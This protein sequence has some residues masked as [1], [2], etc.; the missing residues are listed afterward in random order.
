MS[1]NPVHC[2]SYWFDVQFMSKSLLDQGAMCLVLMP[3]L[4]TA[5]RRMNLL[6][7]VFYGYE[8]LTNTVHAWRSLV[9]EFAH[10]TRHAMPDIYS[11]RAT[12]GSIEYYNKQFRSRIRYLLS[13]VLDEV[14][15]TVIPR[16]VRRLYY[17]ISM[18]LLEKCALV[19]YACSVDVWQTTRQQLVE[20]D[21]H[22]VLACLVR[23]AAVHW[24][25]CD[26]SVQHARGVAAM[27]FT[28]RTWINIDHL[29]PKTRNPIVAN[30]TLK[31]S[32]LVP[33]D[34]SVVLWSKLVAQR[35]SLCSVSIHYGKVHTRPTDLAH[36]MAMTSFH[37]S[38]Q[39]RKLKCT[40]LLIS[41]DGNPDLVLHYDSTSRGGP[42]ASNAPSWILIESNHLDQPAYVTQFEHGDGAVDVIR[43]SSTGGRGGGQTTRK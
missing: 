16:D 29:L 23:S 17:N 24:S 12:Y 5:L 42:G 41:S 7:A 38:Q 6:E 8:A 33:K 25:M 13:R 9:L 31:N 28:N 14:P 21:Q 19:S 20:A 10:N 3:A 39:S 22:V 35:Q 26:Q 36:L 27:D 32:D 18:E 37:I 11:N 40:T 15:S 1:A 4:C 43:T 30:A 34:V 2:P